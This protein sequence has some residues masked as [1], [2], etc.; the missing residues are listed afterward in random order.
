MGDETGTM[1]G[2][3]VLVA[4]LDDP[5]LEAIPGA[6]LLREVVG[7][8]PCGLV[9]RE[10]GGE[11]VPTGLA[12]LPCLAYLASP[13]SLALME[14]ARA[15][16]AQQA[17]APQPE[18]LVLDKKSPPGA[19]ERRLIEALCAAARGLGSGALR[20][21]QRIARLRAEVETL[22]ATVAGL[23]RFLADAGLAQLRR[24]FATGTP[25][26]E[27][28]IELVP[29]AP[30]RQM[31]PVAST[32]FAAL[33]IACIGSRRRG[34]FLARLILLEEGETLAEWRVSAPSADG[35]V[36]LGL[37]RAYAGLN[38]TLVLLV[39]PASEKTACANLA[40]GAHQPLVAAQL[41]DAETGLPI[42]PHGL[43]LRLYAAIP[44][45]SPPHAPDTLLPQGARKAPPASYALHAV[46]AEDL[47]RVVE[48]PAPE[49]AERTAEAAPGAIFVADVAAIL[50]RAGAS[51]RLPLVCP[52]GAR[53][54]IASL[55]VHA[56]EAAAVAVR[57]EIAGA[58]AGDPPERA[59]V[60]SG[61]GED[62]SVMLSEPLP[63]ARDVL[64]SVEA[65]DGAGDR[66]WAVLRDL[67]IYR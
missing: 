9:L 22:G 1:T 38:R 51:A 24:V 19:V 48:E 55:G 37:P 11:P 23:D 6:F 32:G 57:I 67:R 64:L 46:P 41:A 33:D 58:P 13:R 35:W 14:S 34:A 25:D 4:G 49:G 61:G 39:E 31:L 20:Q 62:L 18:I 16:I 59:V 7:I 12:P 44:G 53:G 8:E 30:L 56:E 26:F 47:A 5:T 52:P 43:A 42:A 27:T 21:A 50:C 36:R 2:F 65:V 54:L 10:R 17:D 29:G 40:L 45:T 3:H 28:Q 60:A 63:E 66:A 15:W